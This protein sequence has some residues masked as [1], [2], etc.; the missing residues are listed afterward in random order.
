MIKTWEKIIKYVIYNEKIDSTKT[1]FF[2]FFHKVGIIGNYFYGSF[3]MPL[4]FD[5]VN[6]VGSY[7]NHYCATAII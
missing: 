7:T 6:K 3:Y 2:F 4:D 1:G 5:K